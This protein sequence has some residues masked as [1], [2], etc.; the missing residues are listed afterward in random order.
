MKRWQ[1]WIKDIILPIVIGLVIAVVV[2]QFVVDKVKVDGTSM[3]PNLTDGELMLNYRVL[4]LKRGEVV[5]FNAYKLAD[6]A[7]KN[8][9]Y[10]KRVIAVP[11]DTVSSNN[12]VLKVNGKVVNQ[13]YLPV[14]TRWSTGNW[15]SLRALSIAKHWS[16]QSGNVVPKNHYFVMGDNRSVS[17][18]SRYW[19][20]VPKD[21]IKGVVKVLWGNG[22]HK[23]NVNTQYKR[24]FKRS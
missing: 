18:D 2:T 22:D 19:G 15:T 23:N 6:D 17:Y 16:V 24:Y 3:E 9:Q 7:A 5:V 10:V 21:K 1:K 12:G 11:G 20:Y 14:E 13:G 4:P 8:T